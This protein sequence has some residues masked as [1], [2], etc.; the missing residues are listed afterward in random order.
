M[1][2][3]VRSPRARLAAR[4]LLLAA[5]LA[6]PLPGVAQTASDGLSLPEAVEL[7]RRNNPEL[8]SQTNDRVTARAAVRA[9]NGNFLPSAF[10]ST[11]FG[12]TA[13]G[14]RRFGSVSLAQQP[15]FYTS[16]Y[17][18]GLQYTLD[19]SQLLQPSVARSQQRATEERIS[20]AEAVLVADVTQRY[21]GVLRAED[22]GRQ[23]QREVERTAASLRLAEA[24]REVGVGISL[25]V[26]RAETEQGQAE[27]RLLEAQALRRTQMLQ[28]GRTLG[29]PLDPDT[30]LESEFA[31]FEPRLDREALVAEALR[32]NP[33]L[34][35]VRAGED[36]ARTRVRQARSAF[37][38]SLNMN[39]GVSGFTQRAADIGPLVEGQLNDRAFQSCQE[40]N[41]IR[42]L[43]GGAQQP[44]LNPADPAAQ[45]IVRD[46]VAAQN[47]GFPFGYTQQPLSAGLSLSLPLFQGFARSLQLQEARA[48]AEDARQQI[49]GEELQLRQDVGTAV[50]QVET[51]FRTAQ[52]LERAAGTAA[53]ELRLAE[54]R[55][56]AGEAA[57]LEVVTAQTRLSEAERAQIDAVYN[58]HQSLALLESLVGRPL[59]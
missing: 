53:E 37:Y 50:L 45:Q 57:S 4:L 41:R 16:N 6:A 1:S 8:L 35:A 20:N 39:V 5:T 30:R 33:R 24:R 49:R 59:R 52:I 19:G 44:C 22:A 38:P 11:G 28:L 9:A 27:V 25:D 54:A 55:F 51:A 46:A 32:A 15:A 21:L 29:V 58:F 2:V 3:P 47:S 18:L 56:R 34:Q 7:A 17:S 26:R 40:Q 42:Q 36:A 48:A 23:A 14:E 10:V 13:A 43:V 12:Y 31:L